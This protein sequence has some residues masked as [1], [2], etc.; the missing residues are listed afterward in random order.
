MANI[1]APA[2][3]HYKDCQTGDFFQDNEYRWHYLRRRGATVDESW[4]WD[5]IGRASIGDEYAEHVFT[6]RGWVPNH[7]PTPAPEHYG[8]F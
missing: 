3:G 6:D 7:K 4:H 1:Q 2:G 8:D 5:L